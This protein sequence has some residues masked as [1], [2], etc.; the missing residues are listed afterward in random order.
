MPVLSSHIDPRAPEFRENEQALR[1]AVAELEE[2]LARAAAGGGEKARTK[3]V[4]RDKLLPRERIAALLDPGSPFLELSR[5]AGGRLYANAAPAACLITGVSRAHGIHV[6][7]VTND[8]T[9]Q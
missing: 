5:L 3:H 1:A 4:E 2:R 8:A 7:G 9:V 6:E